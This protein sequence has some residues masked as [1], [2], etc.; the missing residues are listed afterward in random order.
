MNLRTTLAALALASLAGC[1]DDA[2]ATDAAADMPVVD[3]PVVDM[4]AVDAPVVDAA[5]DAPSLDAADATA[6]DAPAVSFTAMTAITTISQNC[7]PAVPPD[8]LTLSGSVTINNTGTVPIGPIPLATG[9]LI[10]LLGGETLATFAL[11][12]VT[13]PMIAPGR[14]ETVTFTKSAGTLAGVGDAGAR[15][16]DIVMCNTPIRVVIP[17]AGGGVPMGSRAASEPATLPCVF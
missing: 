13:I 2:S 9:Q 15:G 17:L 8:P 1:A 11:T 14:S 7:M 12:P 3:T 5:A 16:C 10:R 4:P 6:V